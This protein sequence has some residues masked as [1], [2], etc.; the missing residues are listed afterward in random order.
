MV[1]LGSLLLPILLSAVLVFVTSSLVH[2]VFRYHARDYTRLPNEDAVRAAMRAGNPAPAQYII[3]YASSMKEA[4]TPEMKQKYVEGPVAVLNLKRPGV[5]SMGASLGQWFV[6][7]LM[8][9][10]FVAYAA[11]NTLPAGT[12]Y[13]EV[14]R[15]VGTI[16]FLAY[17]AGVVPAAIWM[18]K[19]W[20]VAWKEVFDG[21]L[22]GLVTAGAFGWLWPR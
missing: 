22:Y 6:F 13:L 21:L 3:P 16:T 7:N 14:F 11:C 18:G 5:Y 4:A 8:V 1:S 20:S 17:G 19:P 9:A 15:V 12:P 2:M 10:V